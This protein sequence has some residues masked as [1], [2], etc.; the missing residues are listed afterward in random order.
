MH[1]DVCIQK[2]KFNLEISKNCRFGK[3]QKYP[4]IRNLE[5]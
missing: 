4:K 3:F 5:N 2:K 1:Y